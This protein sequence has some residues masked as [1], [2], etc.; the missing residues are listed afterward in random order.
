[1]DPQPQIAERKGSQ[2][3]R[4][5]DL[6]HMIQGLIHPVKLAG[7]SEKVC[8]ELQ[9]AAECLEPFKNSTVAEFNDFLVKAQECVR[10]GSWPEPGRRSSPRRGSDGPTI[11]VEQAA[12]KVMDLQVRAN[13]TTLDPAI[14]ETELQPLESLQKPDLLRVAQEVGMSMASRTSKQEI[15]QSLR[16]RIQEG[17]GAG[18]PMPAGASEQRRPVLNADPA[19]PRA[20]QHQPT[21]TMHRE[22]S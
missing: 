13:D 14:I 17:R 22:H 20:G 10:T 6:Q 21:G 8:G 5:A 1:M 15:L 19:Q 2:M 4:V 3:L 7:A 12:Q 16:R 18:E 11:T 9:R